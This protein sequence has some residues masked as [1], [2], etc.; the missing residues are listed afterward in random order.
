MRAAVAR[1]ELK[2]TGF[3]S[4]VRVRE[5]LPA[6]LEAFGDPARLFLNLNEPADYERARS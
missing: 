1:G 2:M 3:W 4:E 6:E 5:V